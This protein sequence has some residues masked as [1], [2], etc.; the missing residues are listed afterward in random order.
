MSAA[1]SPLVYD[2]DFE[3][4]GNQRRGADRRRSDR[5]T[6][7][8][9]ADTL[10]VATLVNHVTPASDAAVDGYRAPQRLRAGMAFDVKA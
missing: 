4:V 2:A 7:K 9:H 3:E 1:T 8:Q 5:R 6:A 10:F